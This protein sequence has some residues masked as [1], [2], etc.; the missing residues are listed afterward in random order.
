[1]AG[2]VSGVA[3]AT[4]GSNNKA[5]KSQRRGWAAAASAGGKNGNGAQA[6]SKYHRSSI[7]QQ[8]QR[9]AKINGSERKRS[10]NIRKMANLAAAKNQR[11]MKMAEKVMASAAEK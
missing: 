6:M 5:A 7:G 9:K 10:E 2:A 4:I 1:L 8:K 11:K 3:T